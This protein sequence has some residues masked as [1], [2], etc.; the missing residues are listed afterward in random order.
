MR[1]NL[2]L[3][4]LVWRRTETK[5]LAL[6]LLCTGATARGCEILENLFWAIII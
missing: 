1:T 4:L 3:L 6:Q 5:V 2:L